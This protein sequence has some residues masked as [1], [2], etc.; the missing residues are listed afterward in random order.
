MKRV[1]AE[2]LVYTPRRSEQCR[3]VLPTRNMRAVTY[4]GCFYRERAVPQQWRPIFRISTRSIRPYIGRRAIHTGI[5]INFT[6]NA[7]VSSTF[8]SVYSHVVK[9]PPE[10]RRRTYST[11]SETS[12]VRGGQCAN[13]IPI[14]RKRTS[15]M[16]APEEP[17]SS[18]PAIGATSFNSLFQSL[19][20]REALLSPFFFFPQQ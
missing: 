3:H 14:T 9:H 11:L 15:S 5:A 19:R 18:R 7:P 2:E 10:I 17:E 16:I 13:G 1:A 12:A 6:K 4:R 8:Y 20:M